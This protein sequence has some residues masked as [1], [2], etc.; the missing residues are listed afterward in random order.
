MENKIAAEL[1]N[2][3]SAD[4]APTGLGT[5]AI[6]EIGSDLHALLADVFTLYLKTKNFHW[7]VSGSHFHD[8]HLMLD[9]QGDQL[10]AMTDDIAERA[11]KL[12]ARTIHSIGDIA[13]SQRLSDNDKEQVAAKAMVRELHVDNQRLAEFMR[14]AHAV[15]HEHGD[16][17]T[18]SLLENWIDQTERR[19]C[20]CRR[21]SGILND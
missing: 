18:A 16:L 13:K 12:G 7:Y 6:L 17:A 4:A 15:C 1:P 9:E 3:H 8:Y 19:S 11:R 10:F 20:F 5:K 21:P 2:N 14:S